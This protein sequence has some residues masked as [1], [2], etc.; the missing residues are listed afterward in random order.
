MDP[1]ITFFP[2]RKVRV[3]LVNW[4]PKRNT[5]GEKRVRID[6]MIPLLDEA[7]EG[8]QPAWILP[9]LQAMDSK[10]SAQ[11]ESKLDTTLEG[12]TLEA[13]DTPKSTGRTLLLT[14]ATFQDFH[15]RRVTKDKQTFVALVFTAN[16]KR[17]WNQLR[18]C[19]KYEECW[20]WCE[21]TPADPAMPSKP[22]P[23]AQMTIAD[24][25]SKD[26]EKEDQTPEEA[27]ANAEQFLN[28]K[29]E[30]RF[31]GY[32]KQEE[33]HAGDH[34]P[35]PAD[36]EVDAQLAA[37]GRRGKGAAV[38]SIEGGKPEVKGGV[39][40]PRGFGKPINGSVN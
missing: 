20:F 27:E 17:D 9:S 19:D 31:G 29:S 12:V 2:K 1:R 28:K 10:D 6:L 22:V 4:Y 23:G 35:N 14:A 38:T 26:V 13:F 30:C 5:E 3:Q 15:L 32:C 11:S 33:F 37:K 25:S 36:A 24:A 21:F 8:M 18:W 34:D 7:M 40:R 16:V 39:K